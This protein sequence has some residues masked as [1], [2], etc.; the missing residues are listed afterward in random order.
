M[1]RIRSLDE[2]HDALAAEFAWR[3]KELHGLK[4]L[5]TVNETTHNR[6]LCIRAAVP[7]LYAHWEGAVKNF[8]GSYLEFVGRQRLRNEQ[9]PDHFLAMALRTLIHGAASTSKIQPCLDVVSFFRSRLTSR[10]DI[11]WKDGVDTKSSL[12][13]SVFREIVISLG[14]DY[15]RF[16]TKEK[17]IDE[18]LLGNRN[19]IAHG[20]Y[21]LIGHGEYLELHDEMIGIMQELFNQIDNA[22]VTRAYRI[23]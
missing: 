16:A 5:V 14:L 20:Q 9:L 22:A 10:C 2:L 18:K 1:A 12:K 21:L 4:T 7:L 11:G 13:A 15:S 3:K 23:S 8:A 19:R 6:D 17:L